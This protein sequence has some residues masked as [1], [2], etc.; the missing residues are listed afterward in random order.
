MRAM[1]CLESRVS[2]Q[3][4]QEICTFSKLLV[5]RCQQLEQMELSC[6]KGWHELLE[7]RTL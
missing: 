3:R 5:I 7:F 6:S 2:S 4:V 1:C